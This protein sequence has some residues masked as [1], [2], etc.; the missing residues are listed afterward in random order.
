MNIELETARIILIVSGAYQSVEYYFRKVSRMMSKKNKKKKER[1]R[2]E[3]LV[4][5]MGSNLLNKWADCSNYLRWSYL[6]IEG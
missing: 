6:E 4:D 1:R 2:L 5:F 3:K